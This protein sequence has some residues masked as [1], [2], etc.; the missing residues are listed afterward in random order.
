MSVGFK[1][2]HGQHNCLDVNFIRVIISSEVT[3]GVCRSVNKSRF[4]QIHEKHQQIL[5]KQ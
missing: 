5:V 4:G 3:T 1:H 2:A